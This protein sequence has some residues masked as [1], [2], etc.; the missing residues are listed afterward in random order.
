MLV[1]ANAH[2]PMA[3]D[4]SDANRDPSAMSPGTSVLDL[5]PLGYIAHELA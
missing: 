5:R 2:L 3:H 1:P 4:D